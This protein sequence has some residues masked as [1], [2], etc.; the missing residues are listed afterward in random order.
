[1]DASHLREH[2]LAHDRLIGS[3]TDAA[4]ALHH[5]TDVVELTLVNVGLGVEL[6]FQD[7]LHRSHRRIAAALA[8]SVHGDVQALGSAQ[9]GSQRVAHCQV[10]VVVGMI[11]EVDLWITLHHLAEILDHL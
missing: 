2:I 10:I 11:V 9:H 4:I 5:P 7:G 8:Q 1:M 6:V 3:H